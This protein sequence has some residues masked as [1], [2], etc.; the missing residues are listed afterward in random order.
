M[1]PPARVSPEWCERDPGISP[2]FGR[3]AAAA[4]REQRGGN[5][6]AGVGHR[7]VPGVLGPQSCAHGGA[8]HAGVGRDDLGLSH[9]SHKNPCPCQCQSHSPERTSPEATQRV[10]L[11]K[12][13]G[14]DRF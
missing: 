7:D 11:F 14:Q 5:D 10:V 4:R 8:Q 6:E 1:C 13:P 9:K 2:A 12:Y 3:H